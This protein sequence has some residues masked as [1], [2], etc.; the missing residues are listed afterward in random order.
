MKREPREVEELRDAT[1]KLKDQMAAWADQLIIAERALRL[2]DTHYLDDHCFRHIL[3]RF[4][5]SGSIPDWDEVE[6]VFKDYHNKMDRLTQYD[7]KVV[8]RLRH[9][10]S[11]DET[12]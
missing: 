11:S 5:G 6:A 2:P 10:S 12:T 7:R 3:S 8:L 4:P 1:Q 9:P